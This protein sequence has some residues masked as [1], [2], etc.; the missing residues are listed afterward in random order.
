MDGNKDGVV[1]LG[2]FLE[3]CRADPEITMN[4][5]AL[6][7]VFWHVI[8][9]IYIPWTWTFGSKNIGMAEKTTFLPPSCSEISETNVTESQQGMER[10]KRIHAS[11]VCATG[12]VDHDRFHVNFKS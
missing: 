7:T 10:K 12:S 1:T 9:P 6:E 2:E 11:F 4:I 3:A 8:R 5:T